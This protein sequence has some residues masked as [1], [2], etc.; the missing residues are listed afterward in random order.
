MLAHPSTQREIVPCLLP[1]YRGYHINTCCDVPCGRFDAANL[2]S[3]IQLAYIWEIL[4]SLCMCGIAEW[5]YRQRAEL[6][7][8]REARETSILI[9]NK[10]LADKSEARYKKERNSRWMIRIIKRSN[11]EEI[12]DSVE[13]NYC[14][15]AKCAINMATALKESYVFL[16]HFPE[17]CEA[18]LYTWTY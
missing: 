8:Q 14:F 10:R 15:M 1:P 6:W 11:F 3:R 5:G 12:V 9:K 16:K 17:K 7:Q 2:P 18:A 13:T 4:F